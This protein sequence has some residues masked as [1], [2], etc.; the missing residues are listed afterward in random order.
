M[1]GSKVRFSAARVVSKR[2]TTGTSPVAKVSY[3]DTRLRTTIA[4]KWRVHS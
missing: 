3:G 2:T 4:A 1:A